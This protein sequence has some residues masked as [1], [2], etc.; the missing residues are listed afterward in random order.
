[1]VF[2]SGFSNWFLFLEEHVASQRLDMIQ[3]PE[4]PSICKHSL[5]AGTQLINGSMPG[6]ENFSEILGM[7]G[8]GISK[9]GLSRF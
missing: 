8:F 6:M 9:T 3:E 4:E 5:N 2:L 1:M 7:E